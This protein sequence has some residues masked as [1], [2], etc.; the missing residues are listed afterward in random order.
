MNVHSSFFHNSQK[1]ETQMSFNRWIIKQTVIHLYHGILL[2]NRKK[3]TIDIHSNLNESPGKLYWV[4]KANHKNLHTVQFQL[5]DIPDKSME[6]ENRLVIVRGRGW[7][8][9]ERWRWAWLSMATGRIFVVVEVQ[10]LDCDDEYM[11]LHRWWNC[12]QLY[13]HTREGNG[14]PL[15]YS[16]LENPTDRGA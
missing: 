13:T 10:C 14:N 16:C 11:A 15:Q 2:I 1:L 9:G 5:Y 8:Y 6:M 3:Q 12:I 7:D 4:K